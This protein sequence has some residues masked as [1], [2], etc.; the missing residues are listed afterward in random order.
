M[1]N[2]KIVISGDS[3]K[4]GG[5]WWQG[6]RKVGVEEVMIQGEERVGIYS[7]DVCSE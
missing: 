2:C 1:G 7:V 3:G 6:D 4:V 5:V